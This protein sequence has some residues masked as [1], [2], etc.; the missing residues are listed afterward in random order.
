MDQVVDLLV[1]PLQF[2]L[3][4]S[5]RLY[6]ACLLSSLVCASIAVTWTTKKFDLAD[7]LKALLSKDYWLTKSTAVD[8]FYM[9]TNNAIR[10]LL[11]LPL[12]GSHLWFTL[13]TGRFLQSNLGDAPEITLPAWL[14]ASLY[15]IVFF[16]LEDCSRFFLHLSM[17]RVPILW[18]LHRVHHS[19]ETLTPL[20]LFRVHPIEAT[21]YFFRGTLVF[22]LVSGSFIWL[23]GRELTTFHIL[24][25]DL[26]GFLFNFMAA[27]LRHSHVWLSFGYFEKW[28]ISPAQHQLHH[29]ID[30]DQPNYGSYLS[31]WDR[32][33]GS[34]HYAGSKRDLVFGIKERDI[35][36]PEFHE[37]LVNRRQSA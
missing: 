36:P 2:F 34:L 16:V 25:V 9:F 30:H 4:P 3:E 26:L 20:T 18:R 15:A 33:N 24:G 31:F 22:G 21:I 14:I 12:V 13:A 35:K 5:K 10:V 19:A 6:W 7:Q 8:V 1:A 37:L 11:L 27:N 23:F 28:F 29:S 32:L 17:H